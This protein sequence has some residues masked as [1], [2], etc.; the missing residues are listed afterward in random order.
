[1]SAVLRQLFM[2]GDS[3]QEKQD[4]LE[5][6]ARQI[7]ELLLSVC[8]E[9]FTDE[10]KS[11]GLPSTMGELERMTPYKLAKSLFKRY[12]SEK[13]LFNAITQQAHPI[14]NTSQ[15][16]FLQFGV[17]VILYRFNILIIPAYQAL[18]VAPESVPTP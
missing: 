17:R 9:T 3:E 12:C 14:L 16:D 13:E 1:M 11:S 2:D 8:L 5:H 7:T 6:Q 15:Q 18:F 10:L 4:A